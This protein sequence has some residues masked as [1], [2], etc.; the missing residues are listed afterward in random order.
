MVALTLG[1]MA[2][3]ADVKLP[4]EAESS[5]TTPVPAAR[6]PEQAG[7]H[8]AAAA[9][10]GDLASPGEFNA[11]VF[12]PAAEPEMYPYHLFAHEAAGLYDI[13]VDLLLAVIMAESR[14]NPSARSRKGA[15]G[16]MQLMPET[17]EALD[18][19]NIFSPE[20][21]I[22]A[23]A[24]HLRW[25]LDRFDGDLKLALAAYNAGLKSVLRHDGVP[26]FRET[27]AYVSKVLEYYAAIKDE[28]LDF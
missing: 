6:L 27:R 17:A 2:S 20:E 19:D 10:A 9:A 14:F 1:L 8:A 16:L 5:H 18:V 25:L 26:P 12:V 24:R 15:K 23:G 11:S 28:N 21:N 4:A 7:A 22:K 13:D 3:I